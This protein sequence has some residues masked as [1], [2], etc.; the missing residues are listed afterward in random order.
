MNAQTYVNYNAKTITPAV[1]KNPRTL[2]EHQI[3]AMKEMDKIN[4]KDTFRS[5][6]VLPTGGGKTLTAVYWLL[7]N[8]IDKDKKV[9][10]I[11]HRHLLLEQAAEAFEL[12]AYSD[13]MVNKTPFKY[14]VISGI[15]DR[16]VHIQNDDNIIIAGKDS[17]IRGLHHLEEWLKDEDVYLIIDEAHHAVAKSYKTIIKYV[18]EHAAR[19]KMLGLTATPFRTSDKES[20]SLRELFTDDIVYKTDLETLIKKEI[21][22][23]PVCKEYET[24]LMLEDKLGVKALKS[25]ESLDVIPENIAKEIASNKRRNSL[26][27]NKY[28]ENHEMYGPTIVFALN[29]AHAIALN[30]LFNEKGKKYGIK[31]EYIISSVRDMIT[32]VTISNEENNRKIEMYRNGEIQVLINVNILTEGT[33]LPKTHTVFLTRPTV[34]T[35]LMTQMVGR[36][37]RGLRAGGTKEAYIV[38]FIDDWNNKIAW[39]NPATLAE[40]P[41]GSITN[42]KNSTDYN[43]RLIAISKLEEFALS[44]DATVDT[45]LIDRIPSIDRIPLGMY[46]FTFTDVTDDQS[47]EHNHQILVYNSTKSAYDALISDLSGLMKEYKIDGEKI[48]EDVLVEMTSFCRDEYF[49]D[50]MIP[51]YNPKD[52]ECLL[53]FYAQ[54]ETEPLFVTFDEIDRKRLDVYTIAKEIIDKDMRES[55]KKAYIENLW[56]EEGSLFP[57]YYSNMI[58]FRS[59]IDNEKNKIQ[60]GVSEQAP[61]ITEQHEKIKRLPLEK[62]KEI[63]LDYYTQL[64]EGAYAKAKDAS[65]NYVCA[66]CHK[67]FNTRRYLQIDH[68]NPMDNGGESVP[69]N[70]QILCRKCNSEKGAKYDNE[71]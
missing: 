29:Q 63:N 62:I 21:L 37:L 49:D 40:G 57:V 44:A 58:F 15:H 7:K 12:N 38:S 1:G 35:V 16:P 19:T 39:V 23:T 22:A 25:I 42:Q 45:S 14:R 50:N 5:L 8:A 31:S 71:I 43:L 20:G 9:L 51:A 13:T 24:E 55:E 17:I 27:V 33:D 4:K 67:V 61:K 68:I 70:L 3:D 41:V 60:D 10:W 6:L 69:E 18:F 65:G 2:Y 52:I 56:N 48:P 28:F 46:M 54:K 47:M 66:K 53:K 64:K 32:G 34:S 36:A 59:M 11:A 26:I 30:A